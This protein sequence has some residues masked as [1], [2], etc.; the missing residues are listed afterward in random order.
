[1]IKKRVVVKAL[2]AVVLLAVVME[3]ASTVSGQGSTPPL[4]RVFR[5][6]WPGSIVMSN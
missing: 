3:T 4:P 6:N 1:M 5:G 2:V